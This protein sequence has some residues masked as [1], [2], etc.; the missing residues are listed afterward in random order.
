[1]VAASAVGICRCQWRIA[2][3]G[4]QRSLV[5]ISVA[6]SRRFKP[7]GWCPAVPFQLVLGFRAAIHG[8]SRSPQVNRTAV[9]LHIAGADSLAWSNPFFRR[10]NDAARVRILTEWIVCLLWPSEPSRSWSRCCAWFSSWRTQDHSSIRSSLTTTLKEEPA[11]NS[12]R[13]RSA[14]CLEPSG[15]SARFAF[16]NKSEYRPRRRMTATS[17]RSTVRAPKP[18]ENR[19]II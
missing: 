2:R 4:L 11:T 3:P 5:S 17:G 19:L 14:H 12:R 15:W 10:S 7:V 8:W 1:M 13:L 16:G 18:L 6:D 9:V